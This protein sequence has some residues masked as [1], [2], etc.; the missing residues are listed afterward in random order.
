MVRPLGPLAPK[1]TPKDLDE[2]IESAHEVANQKALDALERDPTSAAH[3]AFAARDDG[4]SNRAPTH[5]MLVHMPTD[6]G[7]TL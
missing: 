1:V 3:V 2:I 5:V 7:A 6:R 4:G